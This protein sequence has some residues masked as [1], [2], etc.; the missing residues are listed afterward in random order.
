MNPV[1]ST[2]Y[3]ITGT[4]A[5]GCSSS[6]T[7]TVSVLLQPT[8]IFVAS[9]YELDVF[10]STSVYFTNQSENATSYEWDFGDG[11]GSTDVNPSHEYPAQTTGEYQVG[12][13]AYNDLGCSDTV[14]QW[15]RVAEGLLFYV[16]NSF[17]P[18]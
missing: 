13:I 10:L 15:I 8:P 1:S 9:D 7:G 4:D 12:L 14:Y 3:T 16:P 17:T 11:N 6:I 2:S 18:D 5:F